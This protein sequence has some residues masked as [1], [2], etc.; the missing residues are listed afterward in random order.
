MLAS[1]KLRD[2]FDGMEL[3]LRL[4][5]RWRGGGALNRAMGVPDHYADRVKKRDPS[6]EQMKAHASYYGGHIER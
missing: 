6:S 1:V 2:G 3:R 5:R 4:V